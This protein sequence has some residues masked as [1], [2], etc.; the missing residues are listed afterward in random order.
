M[1]RFEQFRY[2]AASIVRLAEVASVLGL[3]LFAGLSP[4][5]DGIRD[6]GQQGAIDRFLREVGSGYKW[7]REV[8]L[9][10]PGDHRSWDLLLRL[11][12]FLVGVE[13]ETRI[14][15]IQALVRRIRE[16]ERDGGTGEIL[17]VLADTAHNRRFV[18]ELRTALGTR[19][20][21]SPRLIL[22]ALRTGR[23]VP[24]SGVVLI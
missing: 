13:V 10:L 2:P 7:M 19:Y 24:G 6:R 15:D 14:R 5:G 4:R 12:N 18:T 23:P 8:L 9:P 22:A 1:V 3:E 17:I 21:T 20:S 11:G 16:R